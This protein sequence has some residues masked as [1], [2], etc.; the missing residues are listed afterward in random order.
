[1]LEKNSIYSYF[2]GHT[3]VNY[4]FEV[5]SEYAQ[6]L[7]T[8]KTSNCEDC[9]GTRSWKKKTLLVPSDANNRYYGCKG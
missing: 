4:K 6:V 8:N 5:F 9:I 3:S 2:E 7:T 1:M